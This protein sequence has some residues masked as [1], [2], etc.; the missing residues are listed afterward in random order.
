MSPETQQKI[1]FSMDNLIHPLTARRATFHSDYYIRFAKGA[2]Y[3]GIEW[4]PL[5]GPS[6]E[7]L[8]APDPL[9]I[10]SLDRNVTSAHTHI[11][12]SA[13]L[14]SVI[15]RRRDPLRP[16][17][18][19]RIHNLAFADSK[20]AVRA[21]HQL[22]NLL[23]NNLPVATYPP[24]RGDFYAYGEYKNPMLQPHPPVFEDKR[25]AKDIAVDVKEGK[26]NGIWLDLYHM[27]EQTAD[28]TRPL[29]PWQDSIDTLLPFIK[30]V[31]F[32]VGRTEYA[33]PNIDSPR[34][35]KTI[36][37]QYPDMNTEA[38]QMLRML[39]KGGFEGPIIVEVNASALAKIFGMKALRLDN[40]RQYH[41]QIIDY[42]K[43]I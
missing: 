18:R 31:H 20:T 16:F 11:H 17:Q 22:E 21:I 38:A 28:G 5:R 40:L 10:A 35:L 13:T 43:R 42:V 32:Q 1:S 6:A 19:M 12:P 15:S 2:G 39:K 14:W 37:A 8:G 36:F 3:D 27:R 4:S 9:I 24:V 26:Y 7:I 41:K 34:E 29:M 30:G 33:D 23:H 25:T